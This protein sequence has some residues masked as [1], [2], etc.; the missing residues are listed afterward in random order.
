MFRRYIYNTR[1]N[2]YPH[3]L[4]HRYIWYQLGPFRV[5]SP[6]HGILPRHGPIV[7]IYVCD[8]VTSSNVAINVISIATSRPPQGCVIYMMWALSSVLVFL[9]SFWFD[10]TQHLW[11]SMIHFLWSDSIF[12]MIFYLS[13]INSIVFTSFI[14]NC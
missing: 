3:L 11:F 2:K 7:Y 10:S 6:L 8:I 4:I 9:C 12:E 13:T 14:L 5:K 1:W